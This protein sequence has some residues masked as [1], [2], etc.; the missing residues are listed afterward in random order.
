MTIRTS[1]PARDFPPEGARVGPDNARDMPTLT[2]SEGSVISAD[3]GA[4]HYRFVGIEI[5]PEPGVY[6]ENMIDLGTGATT[7]GA[8]PHDFDFQRC[9]VHGDPTAGSRRGIALNSAS[10]SIVDS[11]FSDFKERGFDSQAICG[12][13]GPGPFTIHNNYLEGAGENLMFGGADPTIPNLVPANIDIRNNHFSK[14]PGWRP[15]PQTPSAPHWT[16]KN[17][18]ELKN[19]EHVVI[20]GN[21]FENNWLDA[22]VGFAILFTPRNQDGNSPWSVVDDVTFS[23][24]IVRHVAAG[25]DIIGTDDIHTSRPDHDIRIL[26][27]LFTDVGG[28]WGF[29]RLFELLNGT[30]TVTIQHNTATQ[31]EIPVFGGDTT[32]HQDF[33]FEDN[34]VPH[35]TYGFL[36]SGTAPGKASIDHYF[37]GASIRGNVIAGG[38]ASELPP[39]NFFP[40]TL[41]AV[42][43]VSLTNGDFHLTEA[44]PFHGKATDGHDPGVDPDAL[45]RAIGGALTVI[46]LRARARARQ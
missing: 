9:Y 19:A 43:F 22:Q 39:G 24:N 29:G 38:T 41:D 37:P 34:I 31:T 12:W 45:D 32:P 35:N 28:S 23:N 8:V 25:I 4:H 15:N 7:L 33:V 6:L 5:A 40:A 21:V 42:G 14:P 13:N 46:G 36:G 26:N 27:N 3:P 44:S 17:L 1:T 20:D 10:T 18:L 11:Y 2:A 16:V 30:T